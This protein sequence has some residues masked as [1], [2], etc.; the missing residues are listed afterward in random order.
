MPRWRAVVSFA[1]AALLGAAV[2]GAQTVSVPPFA[3]PNP[4]PLYEMDV[5][6]TVRGLFFVQAT[7][8]YGGLNV[9]RFSADQWD[10]PVVAN[11]GVGAGRP[12]ITADAAGNL[13][14]AWE[15]IEVYGRS[16]DVLGNPAGNIFQLSS[17]QLFTNGLMHTA[18]LSTGAAIVW[19][20]GGLLLVRLGSQTVTIGFGPI[21]WDVATTADGGCLIAWHSFD[22][23]TDGY[24][25]A[26]FAANGAVVTPAVALD[27]V[28]FMLSAVAASPTGD[29]FMVVGVRPDINASTPTIVAYRFASD[30]TRRGSEIAVDTTT[31]SPVANS[32]SVLPDVEI[33]GA[34]AA[35]VVWGDNGPATPGLRARVFE[36]DGTPRGP[37][38]TLTPLIPS[39]GVHTAR[40][41]D[42]RFAN[43]WTTNGTGWGSVVS[44]CVPGSAVCGDGVL[45]P[46]CERCDAGSGNDDGAPDACRTTC[47]PA[48]CGD[49]V[50]DSGEE[51]DDGNYTACDGCDPACRVETG[52]VCGDGVL[53]PLCGEECDDANGALLDGCTPAC[54]LER[55][56]GGGAPTSDCLAEWSIDNPT[57][58]PPYDKHGAVSARQVCVDNDPRCDFDGGTPGSCTFK[59]RLCANNTDLPACNAPS[60]LAAWSV[61]HPSLKQAAHHPALMQIRDS[62]LATVPGVLL[63]PTTRDVC[64]DDLALVLPLRARGGAFA[65]AKLKLQTHAVSYEGVVDKDT[66]VLECRPAS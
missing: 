55:I 44:L 22:G 53:A 57:T 27:V 31:R 7:S 15:G 21:E 45:A 48:H 5:A 3:A 25:A 63:G 62:L 35:Y 4:A 2:A 40:M 38:T 47:L 66:L 10:V 58:V 60:R 37:V 13:I 52:V 64:T 59:L 8:Y 17:D 20:E 54:R 24:F 28:P 16:L 18:G 36:A 12:R 56:P 32:S 43:A 29:G 49:G 6:A 41:P 39:S 34:D 11:L 23:V 26:A 61:D 51:C 65:F 50:V 33:D 46:A 42:G 19:S 14:L 9:Q 1:L 30:G